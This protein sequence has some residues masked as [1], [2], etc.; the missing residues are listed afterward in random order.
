MLRLG[1]LCLFL[2]P[3]SSFLLSLHNL[4][5]MRKNK[6]AVSVQRRKYLWRSE[7]ERKR[8]VECSFF[9]SVE[10]GERCICAYCNTQHNTSGKI[11]TAHF[12]SQNTRGVLLHNP[13][14]LVQFHCQICFLKLRIWCMH[15]NLGRHTE[16]KNKKPTLQLWT[17]YVIWQINNHQ[18]KKEK[19]HQMTTT[20]T[21]TSSSSKCAWQLQN[22]KHKIS[23]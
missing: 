14:R 22:R 17:S 19:F 8:S 18:R 11:N 9:L 4:S 2:F 10:R 1:S 3:L 7:W 15:N 13:T 16:K 20:S 21:S 12:I 23:N 5:Q 6:Q